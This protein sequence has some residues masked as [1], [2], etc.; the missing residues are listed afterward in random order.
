M[1]YGASLMFNN[2]YF[3]QMSDDVRNRW[4]CIFEWPTNF[5]QFLHLTNLILTNIFERTIDD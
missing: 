2:V 3:I 1:F 4:V 5:P